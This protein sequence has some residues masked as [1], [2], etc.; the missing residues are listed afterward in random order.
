MV[1]FGWVVTAPCTCELCLL[2]LLHGQPATVMHIYYRRL[3][4]YKAPKH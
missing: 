3:N 2:N 1:D 4:L